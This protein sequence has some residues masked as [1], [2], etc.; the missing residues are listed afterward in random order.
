[1]P[2]KDGMVFSHDCFCSKLT[3]TG[4]FVFHQLQ[5]GNTEGARG[6]LFKSSSFQASNASPFLGGFGLGCANGLLRTRSHD[7][8]KR[9][10][11]GGILL[12]Q[13]DN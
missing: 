2:L 6:S 10:A 4:G 5:P 12:S 13:R 8:L 3:R 7:T 11:N 1:M 9:L